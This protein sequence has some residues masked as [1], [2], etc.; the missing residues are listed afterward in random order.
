MKN[1]LWNNCYKCQN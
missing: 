1:N